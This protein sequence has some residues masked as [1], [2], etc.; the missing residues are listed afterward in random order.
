MAAKGEQTRER[1]IQA[2]TDMILETGYAGMSLEELLKATALTKGAFFHHFKSKA[3]LAS[4]VLSRFIERDNEAMQRR[5]EEVDRLTDDPL[6]RV[7]LYMRMVEVALDEMGHAPR[8]CLLASYTSERENFDDEIQHVISAQFR[9]WQKFY[10]RKFQALLDAKKPKVPVT[11]PQLAEMTT[12]LFEGGLIM[13][14]ALGD[15]HYIQR[16]SR[17]LRQYI[18]TIFSA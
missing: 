17:S 12:T 10:Q 9:N 1:L 16:Q 4:A 8:G 5:S 18:E 11:A 7:L 3:D 2:A 14:T 6:Q 15:A 13:A